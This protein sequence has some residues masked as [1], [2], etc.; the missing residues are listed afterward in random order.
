MPKP[1]IEPISA[2][3]SD[4]TLMQLALD[5]ISLD[6]ITDV[7]TGPVA[8]DETAKI[9]DLARSM[10]E[11]GQLQPILVRPDANGGYLLVAGRRRYAAKKI[12]A[13]L[14]NEPV[15]IDALVVSKNDEEAWSA[16][17]Q[18][19]LQRRQFSPIELA[20]NIIEIKK[21][22][23]LDGDDW[24]KHVAEFLHVS[25]ATIT[26]H[27]KLLELDAATRA[28]VHKGEISA[29]SAFD[30][31]AVKEDKRAQVL[32]EA[33]KLAEAEA[34]EEAAKPRRP[35]SKAEEKAA[36]AAEPEKGKVKRKHVLEAARKS[37]ALTQTKPLTRG[38]ILAFFD[39]ILES[40]DP[41]PDAICEFCKT[42]TGR[43]ATGIVGDRALLNKLD[44]I[45]EIIGEKPASDKPAKVAKPRKGAAA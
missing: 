13:T 17:L 44:A 16:S 26:Q 37:E 31:H 34:A 23:G 39:G 9:D 22:K 43:W 29:Q 36:A 19:N 11:Q 28:K 32:A 2:A 42:L 24:S 20:Q 5:K 14:T 18:E 7:R 21:R 10:Y 12:I 3:P 41:Y 40:T 4:G 15:T 33:E 25:R 6:P 30:L 38:E 35:R 1:T 8:K 45:A 27:A